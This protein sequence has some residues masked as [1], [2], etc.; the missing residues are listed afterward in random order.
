MRSLRPAAFLCSLGLLLALAACGDDDAPP[1]PAVDAGSDLSTGTDAGPGDDASTGEDAATGVDASASDDAA[2][3]D[4][5]SASD[6]AAVRD[7]A[8]ASD[9]AATASDMCTPPRCPPI[10]PGC[11][12]EPSTNP[13]ECPIVKCED[14]GPGGGVG[15]TCGGLA[16][17]CGPGL[18]CN[19]TVD[20]DCGFADGMG[21]CEMRPEFC[22]GLFAPVCGCDGMTYSNS[23]V[24]NGAG[25]D[26]RADGECGPVV[27]PPPPPP[28]D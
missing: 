1:P 8:S 20:F 25:T 3:R 19:F 11:T 21:V 13:C 12:I 10:P 16:G 5:A 23:C 18:F 15:D 17:E 9:D 28:A 4:D 6:D 2:V 26:V 7:D 14:A 24:A 22:T 27:P